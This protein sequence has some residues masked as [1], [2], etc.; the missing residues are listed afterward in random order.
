MCKL[1]RLKILRGHHTTVPDKH[2]TAKAK[3]L[4]PVANDLLNRVVVDAVS[5]PNVM[6]D[7]PACN[8]DHTDDDLNVVRLA[9]AT[10]TVFGEALGAGALEVR[11]G[12][13][14]KDQVWLEAKE[15][16]EAVVE[17][18]FDPLLGLLQLIERPVPS[19]ELA[20][21]H[22][23]AIA[24]VPVRYEAA[25]HA[26]ADEVGLQPTGRSMF[27]GGPDQPIGDEHERPVSERYALG[28]P[29]ASVEDV[30]KAK[31]LEEGSVGDYG[32][33]RGGVD[34]L[35]LGRGVFIWL[36]IATEQA[37]ELSGP[38]HK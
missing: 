2:D 7:R 9:I 35:E 15:V 32:S 38:F 14:V 20:G 33:P 24:L 29:Q 30:P 17:R 8:H 36:E 34:Y 12:D 13:V 21:M 18:L 4:L 25:P 10:V 3:S 27:A 28:S 1:E 26:I 6:G 22:P 23:H 19:L 37:L 5:G 31:L 11:A 16:A